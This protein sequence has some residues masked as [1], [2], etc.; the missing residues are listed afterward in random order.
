[1][2]EEPLTEYEQEF[3]ER[4][5]DDPPKKVNRATMIGKILAT[6]SRF[7]NPIT[8]AKEFMPVGQAVAF[9][10]IRKALGGDIPA[11]KECL[12]SAYGPIA[13]QTQ[14][15]GTHEV[16]FR[17]DSPKSELPNGIEIKQIGQP[18]KEFIDAEIINDD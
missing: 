10:L 16:V 15:T 1:M 3:I 4:A 7:V 11:I 18:K 17:W 2:K 9:S 6:E 8:G 12:D 14:V 13:Q 5:A